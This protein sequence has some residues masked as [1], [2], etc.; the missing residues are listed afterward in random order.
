MDLFTRDYGRLTVFARG[1]RNAKTGLAAVL[2]SFQPLLVS[3]TAKSDT[4]QLDAA[5]LIGEPKFLPSAHLLSGFYLNELLLKLL[6]LHD[7]QIEVFDL[8]AGTL[9][10]LKNQADDWRTLR[11]FE[12][13][14]LRA[15]GFGLTLQYEAERGTPIVPEGC[16][17]YAIEQGAFR[18]SAAVDPARGVYSGAALLALQAE[19]FADAQQISE[20][21]YLLRSMLDHVLDGRRLQTREILNNLRLINSS[22]SS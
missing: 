9:Q 16:Y 2:Q 4:G 14:L 10:Q 12:K 8:Y 18:V 19:Q 6:H 17:R 5:E 7:P 15:L 1:V 21:R 11:L 22:K 3:W 20:A 13:H